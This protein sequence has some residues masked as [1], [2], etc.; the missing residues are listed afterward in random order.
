VLGV[1]LFDEGEFEGRKP[2]SKF[3]RENPAY[4]FG[5]NHTV[6]A[7]R[8]H[9]VISVVKFIQNHEPPTR[10]LTV[11]G[12]EGAGPVVAAARAICG[13]AIQRA[14]INTG[15]IHDERFRF[16]KCSGGFQDPNFVPGGAKYGDLPGM[17]ALGAPASTF[18][19]SETPASVDLA[20]A[21][22]RQAGG[23]ANLELGDA[24][25]ASRAREKL[26]Q[27]VSGQ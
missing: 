14:V 26:M 17:L 18:L 1:D 24:G 8:V 3:P 7:Q 19:I 6:F 11:V 4:V 23:E 20:I 9:D 16:S 10:T 15:G 22:Y 25:D 5:Y 27:Y 13:S 21:L 12:L 2:V